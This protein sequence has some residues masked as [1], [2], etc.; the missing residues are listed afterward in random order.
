M[1]NDNQKQIA[2]AIIVAGIIIAGAILLKDSGAQ[3]PVDNGV[4][5]TSLAPVEKE[6]RVLGNSNA[7][8]ALILYEDFQCPFCGAVSGLVSDTDV[9]KYLK[10]IDPSWTP[11]MIG[12]NDYVKNGNVQFVY[13]DFAFLGPES[14][15]SAEAA[16]C[17]GDQGKFWEYHDYLYTHQNGEN[18]GN[19]SDP[20]LK[21]FAKN[22]GLN[23]VQFD[24]CLDQS[25]Y[26]QAV[27]DSKKEGTT[28]GVTGT[29]KGFI[30]KNGKIVAT[31]DGAESWTMV[32]PKID[33]A[34][35]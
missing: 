35:K 27:A 15:R 34:L 20:N 30:L 28:A 1:Q 9:I 5:I 16:R 21:Y 29:P 23:V 19:F 7:K 4:S 8:V 10:Q 17:A 2:G 24:Q 11:F 3:N 31:I 33:N 32:K 12:I 22:L 14:V 25:K 26:A 13:R 18:K 6:D